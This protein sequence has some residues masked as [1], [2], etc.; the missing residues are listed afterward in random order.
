MQRTVF[1]LGTLGSTFPYSG[2]SSSIFTALAEKRRMESPV[3]ICIRPKSSQKMAG[4][5]DGHRLFLQGSLVVHLKR[6]YLYP[7]S[8]HF[9]HKYRGG[10]LGYIF[11]AT[12]YVFVHLLLL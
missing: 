4:Y 12:S 8:L 9:L 10:P 7:H 2:W 3:C 6:P 11:C 5:G 1:R